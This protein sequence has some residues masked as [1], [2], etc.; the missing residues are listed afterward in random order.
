MKIIGVIGA[1]QM[2]AGIAQVSAAAGYNVLLSD[3]D[4]A[5]AEKGKAGIG[6]ALD[7]LVSKEKM[8]SATRDA[9]MARIT[10]IAD[11]ADF[12]PSL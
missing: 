8:D 9:I 2:G 12:A 1:G 5:G 6:K 11:H 10:P 7:R 4:L 3:I